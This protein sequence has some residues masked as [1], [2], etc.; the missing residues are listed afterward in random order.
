M[1]RTAIA[2]LLPIEDSIRRLILA[3]ADAG[4]IAEAARAGG[5]RTMGEDG[6]DKALAGVTSLE[7]VMRIAPLG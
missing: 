2:E 6:L 7:E 5:M 4:A 3:D 1:G